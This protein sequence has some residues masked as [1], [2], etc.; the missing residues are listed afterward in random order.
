MDVFLTGQIGRALLRETRCRDRFTLEPTVVRAVAPADYSASDL[1]DAG[2]VEFLRP[3]LPEGDLAAID[4]RMASPQERKYAQ[5]LRCH[6]TSGPLPPGSFRKLCQPGKVNGNPLRGVN[7]YVDSPALSYLG[8]AGELLGLTKDS[9]MDKL[10]ARIVCM[11]YGSEICG[12]FSLGARPREDATYSIDH[13]CSKTALER[14]LDLMPSCRGAKFGRQTLRY[15]LEWSNSPR[16]TLVGLAFANPPKLGGVSLRF[17]RLNKTL[18][19]SGRS[20]VLIHREMTPDIRLE[21]YGIA[22]EYNGEDSHSRERAMRDDKYRIDDYATL[23]DTLFILRNED[24]SDSGSLERTL[25]RVAYAMRGRGFVRD[26]KRVRHIVE[27]GGAREA[28]VQLIQGCD[29]QA[30]DL[31]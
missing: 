11:A 29:A 15:V 1:A 8:F 25:L 23:G 5:G 31:R 30:S 12:M 10:Q 16:E 6:V 9:G 19:L 18:D 4:L 27:D 13:A 2:V 26:A 7:L 21:R 24:V 22:V 20:D 17:D 14:Y 3:W 28:R